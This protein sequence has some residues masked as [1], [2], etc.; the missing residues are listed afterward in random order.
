MLERRFGRIFPRFETDIYT[1]DNRLC[2]AVFIAVVGIVFV[3]LLVYIIKTRGV[4]LAALLLMLFSVAVAT[5]GGTLAVF[6]LPV[7][8]LS[9]A[10]LVR[11][12]AASP[13]R[14]NRPVKTI[15]ITSAILLCVT[16]GAV[17]AALN[18]PEAG[19]ITRAK[20]HIISA[21]D[22][23]RYG[24]SGSYLPHGDFTNLENRTTHAGDVRVEIVMDEPDSLYFRGFVGDEYNGTGWSEL[25]PAERAENAATFASLHE[26]G[27]YGQTQTAQAGSLSEA[28]EKAAVISV[29]NIGESS[30]YIFAPYEI[31]EAG[32]NLLSANDIGDEKLR[33]S[34]LRGDREYQYWATQNLVKRY[35]EV[36]AG[37]LTA[38]AEGGAAAERYM[39]NESHY[40]AYVYA[41]YRQ[42]PD[43]TRALIEKHLG[44]YDAGDD[45]HPPYPYVKQRILTFLASRAA[46]SDT[47]DASAAAGRDFFQNFVEREKRGYDVHY[48]TAA[49]LLV[50]YY[51]IPAR[52]VEGYLIT[53]DDAADASGRTLFRL[54]DTHAHAW[55]EFY[56]DGVGWIPFEATPTYLNVMEQPEDISEGDAGAGSLRITAEPEEKPDDADAAENRGSRFSFSMPSISG[57]TMLWIAAALAAALA[58]FALIFSLRKR[59]ALRRRRAACG[60]SDANKA[61]QALLLYAFDL[62]REIG[63]GGQNT[64]L[65][66]RIGEIQALTGI[67]AE[68]ITAVLTIHRAARFGGRA[69]SRDEILQVVRFKDAALET[70]KRTLP[71]HKKLRLRL[72]RGLY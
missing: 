42:L 23:W 71:W 25:S 63:L 67:S 5:L 57:K 1:G 56:V 64:S 15:L 60:S 44:A 65:F 28:D 66:E 48:T 3:S 14:A 41:R 16:G 40:S 21:L 17:F 18:L 11:I 37:V 32:A 38:A 27:F 54:D 8:I 19:G 30:R 20:S 9:F 43:S 50:R 33:S 69:L 26:D 58:L 52:Y 46:Y 7:F 35:P 62:L 34:G 49:A 59:A 70:V 47:V 68:E 61:A 29:K 55:A 53:P 72:V 4:L 45:W 13:F 31:S 12:S 22:E 51:G 6:L 10:L 24:K 2:V 36:A 39:K